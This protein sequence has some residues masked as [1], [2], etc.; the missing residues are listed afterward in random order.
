MKFNSERLVMSPPGHNPGDELLRK[1]AKALLKDLLQKMRGASLKP[2][3]KRSPNL[4]TE[5]P[6]NS[7]QIIMYKSE[8]LAMSP[9][10]HNPC[11]KLL[12]MMTKAML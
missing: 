2:Q 10:G 8:R 6:E 7:L 5:I 3:R 1:V 4:S 12:R 9:P 11:N